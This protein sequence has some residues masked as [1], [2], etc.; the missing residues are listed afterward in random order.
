MNQSN[1]VV[2]HRGL[3]TAQNA[4]LRRTD[5]DQEK[6]CL[7]LVQTLAISAGDQVLSRVQD[8]VAVFIHIFLLGI[9]FA[10]N[11]KIQSPK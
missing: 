1:I 8:V 2:C 3:I 11:C 6:H 9:G 5:V 10:S 7:L 4:S